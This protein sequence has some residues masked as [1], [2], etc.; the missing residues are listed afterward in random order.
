MAVVTYLAL[1][2]GRRASRETLLDLC[3]ADVDPER[4]RGALRQVLF[5][6]RRTLGEAAIVGAEELVLQ[7]PVSSDRDEFLDAIARDDLA[8]GIARYTGPFLPAFGVPGGAAF[9]QWADLERDRLQNLFGRSAELL[10]R[11]LLNESRWRDA[12]AVAERARALVPER[13]VH[14]RLVL[15]C[16]VSAGDA[17]GATVEADAFE[18]YLVEEERP[19][20]PASRALIAQAR[21]PS[22]ARPIDASGEPLRPELTGRGREFAAIVSAWQDHAAQGQPRVMEVVAPAGMGKSRLLQEVATRI[23]AL[24]GRVV[25]AAAAARDRD[26]PFAYLG[27]LAAV[28]AALPGARGIAPGSA[29]VLVAL[30]PALSSRFP[31]S[32]EFGA[33]DELVRRRLHALLDLLQAVCVEQPVA[34]LVDDAHWL[35]DASSRVLAALADRLESVPCLLVAAARPERALRLAQ[36]DALELAP[37][38]EGETAELLGALG[39][40]PA[41]ALWATALAEQV[42]RTSRGIP[43]LVLQSLRLAMDARVLM[44]TNATWECTDP[45]ALDRLLGDGEAMRHRVA[46]VPELAFRVLLALATLGAAA[47]EDELAADALADRSSTLDALRRLEELGLVRRGDEGWN[48]THDE[49]ARWAVDLADAGERVLLERR[50][51]TR[52]LATPGDDPHRERRGCRH[53]LNAGDVAQLG[54][55][56]RA[57][58]HHARQRGDRRAFELLAADVSGPGAPVATREQ[59]VRAVPWHWRLGLWSARR[60]RAAVAATAVLVLGGTAV[61][62]VADSAQSER[63]RLWY[64][65]SGGRTVVA[66][67]DPDGWAESVQPIPVSAGRSALEVPARGS[68]IHSPIVGAPPTFAAWNVDEGGDRTIDVWVRDDRGVR[69]VTPRLRDQVV[70]D[71]SPDGRHLI[72]ASNERNPAS[73]GAYDIAVVDART[74]ASR[75]VSASP[76]HEVRPV[77]SP[78][79]TR[80]AFLRESLIYPTQLCVVPFDGGDPPD[81]RNPA[82][83]FVSLAPGWLNPSELLV[84]LDSG[85][86]RPLMRYNWDTGALVRLLGPIVNDAGLSPDRKWIVAS[87]RVSGVPGLRQ[88]I[89]AA[90][91]TG[92]A[93]QVRLPDS[94]VVLGRW[95]EGRTAVEPMVDHLVFTDTSRILHVGVSRLLAVQAQNSSGNAVPIRAPIRWRSSDTTIAT[96]DGGGVVRASRDGRVIITADLAGWRTASL[97]VEVRGRAA[98]TMLEER[99]QDGWEERWFLFGQPAP[100]VANGPGGI[101]GFWNRGDGVYP[102]FV[103]SR[104]PFASTDG[105]G[106]EVLLSTPLTRDTWIRASVLLLANLDTLA[107]LRSEPSGPAKGIEIARE[108]GCGA[109]YP[110]GDGAYGRGHLTL[111]GATPI[112]LA[113]PDSLGV[114]RDGAWWRVRVQLFPDGRCGVAVNGVPVWRSL[115]PLRAGA[116]Y[117]IRL[118]HESVDTRVL[119][120]PLEVW[121]GVRTDVDW[122]LLPEGDS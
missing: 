74:G 94:A 3:W 75:F 42:H 111:V 117:W 39:A 81:C 115:D 11:R 63:P 40:L 100:T 82:G 23:R 26:I 112:Q 114:R 35:D 107:L 20:E 78:D 2:P 97:V 67:P 101:V 34:L 65:L 17:L 55:A 58:V 95:W 13:E 110:A 54:S 62:T 10:T 18:R 24:G 33:G 79:G 99:W 25:L 72:V 6:L 104:T 108:F 122:S 80:I 103:L 15:E 90:D 109:A 32:P 85:S 96:V 64:A 119:H 84:V 43:L 36:A 16:A 19:G 52:L 47:S 87:A 71:I 69:N 53:L 91:G 41:G 4:G 93:R 102:N 51:G 5:H 66:V 57:F 29:A 105:L 86:T 116:R 68:Q 49:V 9:E 77:I 8:G 50:I 22:H 70:G 48:V 27:D 30:H 118:G 89:I 60:Q 28:L 12:R 44:L 37:L 73:E 61:S 106:L 7:A 120:G 113:V 59:L 45:E 46:D 121:T 14:W 1:T 83:T 98:R 31:V 38:T 21:R 76:D 92:P 56:F 88:W